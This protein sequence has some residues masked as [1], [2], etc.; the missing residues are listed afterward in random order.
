MIDAPGTDLMLANM[1]L[2]TAIL[3]GTVLVLV[4]I[5][6]VVYQKTVGGRHE[7]KNEVR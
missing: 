1:L 7:A 3:I 5:G 2:A 4:V 6:L